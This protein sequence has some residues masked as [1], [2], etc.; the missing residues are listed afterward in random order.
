[1][2]HLKKYNELFEYNEYNFNNWRFWGKSGCGCIVI[3]LLS[4]RILLPFRGKFVKEPLTWG[5]WGGKIDETDINIKDEVKREL[6]EESG[7]D[8][9]IELI[10]AYIFESPDKS[11]KYYNFI[12]LIVDEFNPILNWETESYRWFTFD[13]MMKISPK[14]FGLEYLLNDPKSIRIIR[15]YTR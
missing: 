2:I 7:F 9:N 8:D 14:H 6:E 15:K 13:K 1:M 10:P 5:L 11:F 12:G 3:S 4:G